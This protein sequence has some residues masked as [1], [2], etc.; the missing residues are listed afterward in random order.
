MI[1]FYD[2]WVFI[3]VWKVS[4]YSW[5]KCCIEDVDYEK[6][7][8]EKK[9]VCIN[10]NWV[11]DWLCLVYSRYVYFVFSIIIFGIFYDYLLK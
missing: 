3:V 4:V 10:I 2:G 9:L 11:F 5:W 8:S 6:R 7:K 1:E